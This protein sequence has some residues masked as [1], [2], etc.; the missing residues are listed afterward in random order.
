MSIELHFLSAV[1]P[2]VMTNIPESL[3]NRLSPDY[4]GIGDY[5][6]FKEKIILYFILII[7]GYDF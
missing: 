3:D 5:P 2:S 1:I 4:S 7:N 6:I